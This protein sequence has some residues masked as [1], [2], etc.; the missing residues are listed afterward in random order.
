ML[1][2][3]EDKCGHRT[4]LSKMENTICISLQKTRKM[5]STLA[6]LQVHHQLVLSRLNQ[7]IFR[8]ATASILQYLQIPM[9]SHTCTSEEFGAVAFSVGRMAN[10]IL[11]GQ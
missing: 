3:L 7:V 6:L 4:R 10:M 1:H 2:G 5:Y 11:L 9:A 8:E